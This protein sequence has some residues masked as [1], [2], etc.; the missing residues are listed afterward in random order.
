MRDTSGLALAEAV[1]D[2]V[3]ESQARRILQALLDYGPA[4]AQE[5]GASTTLGAYTVSKRRG[6]LL[7]NGCIEEMAKRACNVT[8]RK[9]H[10]VR[11][12]DQGISVVEGE[13]MP[14]P[15]PSVRDREL[16]V[17][18]EAREL[19]GVWSLLLEPSSA[20][21]RFVDT[22][23]RLDHHDEAHL[24]GKSAV[25][26]PWG[27]PRRAALASTGVWLRRNGEEIPVHEMNDHHLRAS[28]DWC[29]ENGADPG[30]QP[31]MQ[32]LMEAA[33]RGLPA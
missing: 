5:L 12:T 7:R 11:I 18:K 28:I 14:R 20:Q 24:G 3:L 30:A 27:S 4:T 29:V 25:R 21:R 23:W 22:V 32:L 10:P 13:D 6:A 19:A 31:L 16:A 33:A 15:G 17:L 26:E 2:G 1:E 9:A 8:G